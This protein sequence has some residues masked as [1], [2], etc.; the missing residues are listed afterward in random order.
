MISPEKV[1]G[2]PALDS[3]KILEVNLEAD[4]GIVKGE[5]VEV[6]VKGGQ[7]EENFETGD[8]RGR[9]RTRNT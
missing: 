8:D 5:N 7:R 3:G 4:K 9:R 1:G 2:N 6:Q